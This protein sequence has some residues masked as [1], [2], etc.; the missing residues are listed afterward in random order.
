MTFK[1]LIHQYLSCSYSG[2]DGIIVFYDSQNPK[3]LHRL[4]QVVSKARRNVPA[5]ASVPFLLIAAST[6]GTA[7]FVEPGAAYAR[8]HLWTFFSYPNDPTACLPVITSFLSHVGLIQAPSPA[9]SRQSSSPAALL[10]EETQS[11]T[12]P[13]PP[14]TV[15]VRVSEGRPVR[16]SMPT[17]KPAP[18]PSELA[19]PISFQLSSSPSSSGVSHHHGLHHPSPSNS[20]NNH[21]HSPLSA[22]ERRGSRVIDQLITSPSEEFELSDVSSVSDNGTSPAPSHRR[23]SSL[24]DNLGGDLNF[25]FDGLFGGPSSSHASESSPSSSR[26]HTP[27][28]SDSEDLDTSAARSSSLADMHRAPSQTELLRNASPLAQHSPSSPHSGPNSD[29]LKQLPPL[30]S[31]L[32]GSALFGAPFDPN[33]WMTFGGSLTTVAPLEQTCF[34]FVDRG[35]P[36][37]QLFLQSCSS[38]EPPYFAQFRALV[39]NSDPAAGSTV[40]HGLKTLMATHALSFEQTL[41]LF[42]SHAKTLLHYVAPVHV[43]ALFKFYGSVMVKVIN[44]QHAHTYVLP[45]LLSACSHARF[46]LAWKFLKIGANPLILD[47]KGRSALYHTCATETAEFLS[48][49]QSYR[50]FSFVTVLLKEAPQLVNMSSYD[51]RRTPLHLAV[52][53]GHVSIVEKLLSSGASVHDADIHGSTPLHYA[54]LGTHDPLVDMLAQEAPNFIHKRF[55]RV[56]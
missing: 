26:P 11:T 4:T 39:S 38:R 27:E 19:P 5:L 18:A 17:D 2:Y 7:S 29:L 55:Y 22:A 28:R 44:T 37:S 35:P 40:V 53:G 21:S 50:L 20:P 42:D 45:P 43:E 34:S 54:V 8:E 32:P 14:L 51:F 6:S 25:D 1:S 31:V 30:E 23:R 3:A 12:T 15:G 10:A 41:R 52:M 49:T 33:Q 16:L 24:V 46:D 56:D 36:E 9:P 48:E 47:Y 13:A